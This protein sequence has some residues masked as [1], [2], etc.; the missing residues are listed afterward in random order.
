M[1]YLS[2]KLSDEFVE[3]YATKPVAFGFPIGGGN[4]LGELTFYSKYS[5]QKPDGSKERWH[6][7]VRRVIEGMYSILKD[8][9]KHNKT[10]WNEN[11]AQ[12]SAQEAYDRMFA[13]KWI[14]PGRGLQM[15]GSELVNGERNPA[16]LY[17]C[18]FISTAKI[19]ARSE[20]EATLPFCRLMDQSMH[21]IGVGFDVEGAGRLTLHEPIEETWTFVVPDSREGWVE[22]WHHLLASYF[23]KNRPKVV[24]D[25]SQ[26]R[27]AGSPIVRFGGKAP[28]PEPLRKAHEK[29]RQLL[30]G[31]DGAL[32]TELDILDINNLG[33]K[34]VVAGGV[35]RSA[36][37]AIGHLDSPEFLSAKDWK[38]HK[39][40]MGKDGWGNLS[41]NTVINDD[42]GEILSIL[43]GIQLNGEPGIFNRD[44]SRRY[45]RLVDA[46]NDRD[47]RVMGLNPCGEITLESHELCNLTETFPMMASDLDDFKRT[48]KF[49]YLYSKAVTLMPTPWP[50]TNEVLTR[51][52]RIGTSM[53]GLALAVGRLGWGDLRKWVDACYGEIQSWDEIYSEWLGVRRSIKTTSVKPS[54]TVSLLCGQTPGVHFP[55]KGGRYCRRQRFGAHEPYLEHF[56]KAGYHTEPDVMDPEF[57]VVVEFPTE[58]PEIR[59]ETQVS[60]WEKVA[61][62]TLMQRYWADNSVSVTISFRNEEADQLGP[63]IKCNEDNLKTMS[64]LP[65]DE[66]AYEQMPYEQITDKKFESMRKRAKAIDWDTLYAEGPDVQQEV[67]CDGDKCEVPARPV[68]AAA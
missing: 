20:Y 61:L 4:T 25:Y 36:E 52:R 27:K 15:M 7:S 66:A 38:M 62:A 29:I 64:F 57:S 58:G 60:V 40:R 44:L 3:G 37:I 30:G 32:I 2:F 9:C 21:G 14:P 5:R 34:A 8:H 67:Y 42:R 17:N 18:S 41:N 39:A 63:V 31:R 12:R 11:K 1:T 54:G 13:F 65:I 28:G 45:G 51:N 16:V 56:R 19:S 53:S 48:M 59:D 24:F 47:H 6:E 22:S 43:P 46:P 50:E 26:I 55:P 33:G 35:R 68:P 10:P 23:F 49:A